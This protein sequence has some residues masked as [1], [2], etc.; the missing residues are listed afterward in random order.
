VIGLDAIG[1]MLKAKG[2]IRVQSRYLAIHRCACHPEA[3]G[4]LSGSDEMAAPRAAEG[5]AI[6]MKADHV[7]AADKA[8]MLF[9]VHENSSGSRMV[10]FPMKGAGTDAEV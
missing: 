6:G 8:H 4:A 10:P 1:G 2:W 3:R 7:E 9:D 5:T